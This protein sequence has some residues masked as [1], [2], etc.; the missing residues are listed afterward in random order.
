M[1]VHAPP[2]GP[3]TACSATAGT[4]LG[5]GGSQYEEAVGAYEEGMALRIFEAYQAALLDYENGVTDRG[6]RSTPAAK[7]P[8]RPP[9]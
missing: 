2:I 4:V 8:T 1:G 5:I 7:R 9:S 3:T 6:R